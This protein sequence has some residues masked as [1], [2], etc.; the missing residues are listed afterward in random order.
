M[1]NNL[2]LLFIVLAA[3]LFSLPSCKKDTTTIQQ[4]PFSCT[5][6]SNIT[7]NT[8]L[9]AGVYNVTCNIEVSN[10]AKLIITPGTTLIF[11]QGN[12]LTVDAG[13]SISALGTAQSPIIFEGADSTKG[14]WQGVFINSISTGNNFTYCTIRD[15][16]AS[17]GNKFGANVSI[18][19]GT[20][21]F[22]NCTVLNSADA[23]FYVFGNDITTPASIDAATFNS[24]TNNNVSNN[25]SYPIVTYAVC[26]GAIGTGNTF[27]G[28]GN[29][30]I[31]IRREIGVTNRVTWAPL[32]IP[33]EILQLNGN[34]EGVAFANVFT[35]LPGTNIVMATG[36]SLYT[37][38]SGTISAVGTSAQPIIIKGLQATAGFWGSINIQSN[39]A[40]N[41]QYCNVS[42]GGGVS[43]YAISS[44]NK[45]LIGTYMYIPSARALT[46]Q[47][48]NLSNS[49]S[50]GIYVSAD[51]PPLTPTYNT[52]DIATSNTFSGCNPNVQM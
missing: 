11:S 9:P 49:G 10:N 33:Y 12:S 18:M 45:G 2:Q 22:S 8:T 36:T 17:N 3:S 6:Y 32:S 29:N 47:H 37:T 41:F 20:A 15:G 24:F 26:A 43:Y 52:A 42:D 38:T 25:N 4:L 35:V 13:A 27:T 51:A 30:Y 39:T 48:C 21:S 40:N 28:N 50:S 1:K 23:G 46:V 44:N 34:D 31:G 14:Y 16:G 5:T 7:T 19:G